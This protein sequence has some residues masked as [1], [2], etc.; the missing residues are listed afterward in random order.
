M[1]PSIEGFQKWVSTTKTIELVP[2]QI[3]LA[4]LLIAYRNKH[5][6]LGMGNGRTMT[7]KLVRDYI[8]ARFPDV[9]YIE[10]PLDQVSDSSVLANIEKY[11]P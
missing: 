9:R 1:E 3:E 8:R 2:C 5:Y 10:L 11:Y 7:V 4:E 6:E